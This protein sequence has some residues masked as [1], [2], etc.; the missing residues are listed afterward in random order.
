ME[1]LFVFAGM[2]FSKFDIDEHLITTYRSD[3]EDMRYE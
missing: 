3:T 2:I 1:G